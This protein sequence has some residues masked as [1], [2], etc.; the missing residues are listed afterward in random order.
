MIWVRIHRT[1]QVLKMKVVHLQTQDYKLQV[2]T[3]MEDIRH[4][5]T[6]LLMQIFQI[7]V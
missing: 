3:F 2:Y 7:N 5:Q 6:L 1:R 4:P